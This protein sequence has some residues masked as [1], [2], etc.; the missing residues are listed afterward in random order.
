M[1]GSK[2]HK[3]NVRFYDCTYELVLELLRRSIKLGYPK[4]S[5]SVDSVYRQWENK[6]ITTFL[7]GLTPSSDVSFTSTIACTDCLLQAFR[8]LLGLVAEGTGWRTLIPKG[9]GWFKQLAMD[10]EAY[11]LFQQTGGFSS[12]ATF[13]TLLQPS[14]IWML[15]PAF[16]EIMCLLVV[17]HCHCI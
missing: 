1:I 7:I 3:V 10:V 8:G 14:Q 5:W 11:A 4:Q 2:L 13:D 16:S 17:G 15:C 6:L 12:F 9:P